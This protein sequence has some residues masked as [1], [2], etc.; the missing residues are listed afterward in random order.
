MAAS[1]AP[2]VDL[3]CRI[4]PI[5]SNG[6]FGKEDSERYGSHDMMQQLVSTARDTQHQLIGRATDKP[7]S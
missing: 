2:L 1:S 7:K 4:S 6:Q 3:L 5:R